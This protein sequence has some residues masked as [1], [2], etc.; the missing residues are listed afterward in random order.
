M[1]QLYYDGQLVHDPRTD[2]RVCTALALDQT[3]N[4]A[5]KLKL[6]IQPTHPLFGT[7]VPM[8][9]RHEMVLVEDGTEL[10]RG[11]LTIDGQDITTATTITCESQLAYLNDS[12]V[13]PYGTYADTSDEPQWTTIAPNTQWSYANWLIDQ[14]NALA[15]GTKRFRIESCE[16][17]ESPLTRSSTVWPTTATELIDK[18]LD[19]YGLVCST[20]YRDGERLLTLR[21]SAR[22][23]PQPVELGTNILDFKPEDD[24][25]SIVTCIVPYPEDSDGPD[26]STYP[27]GQVGDYYKQGDRIWS[28]AGVTRY[29]IVEERRSYDASTVDG[30]VQQ[31][32]N[33]LA[34]KVTPVKSLEVSVVD[35]HHVD[36][37][38]P[39]IRLGD[40]L[41]V[42]SMPHR[43]DQWMMASKSH[44]DCLDPSDSTWT[45]GAL[46]D[47][48][49]KSHMVQTMAVEQSLTSVVQSTDAISAEAQQAAQD[50]QQASEDA[51]DAIQAAAE[52]RRV[53]TSTPVP[54]YDVGDIWIV[55]DGEIKECIVA[56]DS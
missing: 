34:E 44:I 1:Y 47:S 42:K 32:I 6:T 18:V 51:Q 30:M 49:T 52:K 48:L 16:L 45:F 37:S 4:S 54:P 13:R 2:D 41:R 55:G 3:V 50:A 36:G 21:R 31:V 9:P 22:M 53:F 17:D 40:M 35:L 56:K 14:H 43:I 19:P 15:D 23:M 24:F 28:L 8:D 5:D 33:D 11:R 27:D 12:K 20:E 7:F 46:K 29:G 10:F 26:I 25:S 39:S 38:I